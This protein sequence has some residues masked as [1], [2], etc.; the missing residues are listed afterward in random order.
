MGPLALTDMAGVDILVFTDT[1]LSRVFPDHGVLS[2]IAARLV[3]RGR[4]RQKSRGGVYDY[5]RGDYI[6]KV[7][8]L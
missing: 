5:D 8:A 3:E 6:D 1:A 4:L 2:P 7:V